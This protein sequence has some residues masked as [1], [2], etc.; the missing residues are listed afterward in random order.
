MA[1]TTSFWP[2][3]RFLSNMAQFIVQV[4]VEFAPTNTTDPYDEVK[5]AVYVALEAA[6][7]VDNPKKVEVL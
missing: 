4:Y 7:L 1:Q 2:A 6:G 5:H 3:R